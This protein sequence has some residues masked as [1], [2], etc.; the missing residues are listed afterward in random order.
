MEK[1][2]FNDSKV[3]LNNFIPFKGFVAIS[4]FGMIFWRKDE[5]YRIKRN[6]YRYYASCVVNH[7]NIHKEQIKD[8][9][10]IFWFLEPLQIIFGSLLFYPLYLL[11]WLI[12]IFIFPKKAYKK[13]LFEQEAYN[14]EDN[15]TYLKNRKHF[16]FF[17]QK[18]GK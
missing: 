9:G 13:I 14:N 2:D 12:N 7:E 3:Y 10:I 5:E 4:L 15:F 17:S 18:K 6:D 11:N 16:A 1:I 8:L